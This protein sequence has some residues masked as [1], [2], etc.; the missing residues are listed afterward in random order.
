MAAASMAAAS[1]PNNKSEYEHWKVEEITSGEGCQTGC[2][3]GKETVAAFGDVVTEVFD[4]INELAFTEVIDLAERAE[5]KETYPI[6]ES[7]GSYK[8][9]DDSLFNRSDDYLTSKDAKEFLGFIGAVKPSTKKIITTPVAPLSLLT[10]NGMPLI[11]LPKDKSLKLKPNDEAETREDVLKKEDLEVDSDDENGTEQSRSQRSSSSRRRSPDRYSSLDCSNSSEDWGNGED[12]DKDNE[13]WSDAKPKNR[14]E[15][16]YKTMRPKTRDVPAIIDPDVPLEQ[17]G[18]ARIKSMISQRLKISFKRTKPKSVSASVEPEL[19]TIIESSG[20]VT[21][22]SEEED[23]RK[24]E[25]VPN[26]DKCEH[27]KKIEHIADVESVEEVE[28]EEKME[29]IDKVKPEDESGPQEELKEAEESKTNDVEEENHFSSDVSGCTFSYDASEEEGDG[30]D[31]TYVSHT[32]SDDDSFLDEEEMSATN[33]TKI[34]MGIEDQS[35]TYSIGVESV[36]EHSNWVAMDDESSYS[37]EETYDESVTR[38]TAY[39]YISSESDD[40]S[41]TEH[42]S[43]VAEDLLNEDDDSIVNENLEISDAKSSMPFVIPAQSQFCSVYDSLYPEDSI[44]SFHTKE[45]ESLFDFSESNL[46]D[47]VQETRPTILEDEKSLESTSSFLTDKSYVD[48]NENEEVLS[49]DEE[50]DAHKEEH[51]EEKDEVSEASVEEGQNEEE[52]E[53]NIDDQFLVQFLEEVSDSNFNDDVAEARDAVEGEVD[54]EFEEEEQVEEKVEEVDD[55]EISE[56]NSAFVSA[57]ND[58]TKQPTYSPQNTRVWPPPR[59]KVARDEAPVTPT[60]ECN[61]DELPETNSEQGEG[62]QIKREDSSRSSSSNDSLH[63][64]ES[65]EQ[66]NAKAEADNQQKFSVPSNPNNQDRQAMKRRQL[67]RMRMFNQH[68]RNILKLQQKAE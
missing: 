12:D 1:G 5:E 50:V 19:L 63:S 22:I 17:N 46:E 37:D 49:G 18:A 51:K 23:T 24:E 16:V 56:I 14:M 26:G 25:E 32:G 29:I 67:S 13:D 68:R 65:V 7:I 62:K 47:E 38:H 20:E 48:E 52:I 54:E 41:N 60:P 6:F 27:E 58:E 33:H 11:L 40:E 3:D 66:A 44:F 53:E 42:K 4:L 57:V 45:D 39:S 8:S 36:T 21:N 10:P 9:D 35:V 28:L 61:G 55:E 15:D 2:S 30:D 64:T 59:H 43:S 34:S 31:R